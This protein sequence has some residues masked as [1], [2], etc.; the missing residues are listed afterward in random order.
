MMK[1]FRLTSG[2]GI[3]YIDKCNTTIFVNKL[4]LFF[5]GWFII[6]KSIV[7]YSFTNKRRNYTM[8]YHNAN[9]Q[10]INNDIANSKSTQVVLTFEVTKGGFVTLHIIA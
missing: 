9:R 1:I 10:Q 2:V 3:T 4:S 8:P 7:P 6:L 5:L